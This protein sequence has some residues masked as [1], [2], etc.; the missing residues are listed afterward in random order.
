MT[1]VATT[2]GGLYARQIRARTAALLAA[3]AAL[4]L[5]LAADRAMYAA[6]ARGRNCVVAKYVG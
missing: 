5:L 4:C 3:A 2:S 6:K 1:G